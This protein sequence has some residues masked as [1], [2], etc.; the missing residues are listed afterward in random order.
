[1]KSKL[2]FE[3]VPYASPNDL[4]VSKE[5]LKKF[6]ENIFTASILAFVEFVTV[7]GTKKTPLSLLNISYLLTTLTW[8]PKIKSKFETSL[9]QEVTHVPALLVL[10]LISIALKADHTEGKCFCHTRR[11]S[12]AMT[13]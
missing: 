7:I 10:I 13:Q 4:D 12:V 2:S 3:N 6:A 1:M 9:T 8:S 11:N 5:R